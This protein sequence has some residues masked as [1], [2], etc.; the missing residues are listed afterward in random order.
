MSCTV[1]EGMSVRSGGTTG[2]DTFG[3]HRGDVF[4]NV[5]MKMGENFLIWIFRRIFAY[6]VIGGCRFFIFNRLIVT[7]FLV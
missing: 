5:V 6:S 7:G 3:W 2:L 1:A 4:K